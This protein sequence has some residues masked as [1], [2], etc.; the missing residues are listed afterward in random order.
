MRT[1]VISLA[2]TLALSAAALADP[3]PTVVHLIY[4]GYS[5]GF[6]MLDLQSDVT[7]GS[8]GYRIEMAGHTA[9]MIG[10]V[11][12]ANWHTEADGSWTGPGVLPAH[13]DNQG[14]FGGELR[15]VDMDYQ[16]GNP[17]L[18][19][20]DPPDDH[21]HGPVPSTLERHTVDG[22]S[23]LALAI[24]QIMD[25]GTCIGRVMSFD[26]RE[27]EDR[28]LRTIGMEQLPNTA[29]SSFQGPA[30]RCDVES[31]TVA[32]FYHN[33]ATEAQRPYTDSIWF[34]RLAPD[35]PPLPVRFTATTH[36]TGR[37]LLY[38]TGMSQHPSGAM[39][40]TTK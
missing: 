9:G 26:G 37:V 2:L 19:V 25:G 20:L 10:F 21:E 17:V 32:G 34:A 39:S 30:L 3:P 8:D 5:A 12:H 38:L 16:Q 27:V 33:D 18:R 23:V 11:Y 29:R 36:H 7:I 1:P 31:H 28:T 35:L 22:L 24:H 6:H 4:E 14:E 13:Y 40:A 15:R